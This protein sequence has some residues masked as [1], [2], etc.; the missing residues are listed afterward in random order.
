MAFCETAEHDHK[1][2]THTHTRSERER[3]EEGGERGRKRT[4]P[5]LPPLCVTP[6]TAIAMSTTKQT[7]M[8]D[9][10]TVKK[11]QTF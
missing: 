8:R 11:I 4:P 5:S 2:H 6:H 1:R 3:R 10:H 9:S 7:G